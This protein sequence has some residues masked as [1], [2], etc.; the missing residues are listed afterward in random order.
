[1]KRNTPFQKKNLRWLLSS[2]LFLLLFLCLFLPVSELFRKKYTKADMVHSFYSL[3]K[4]SLDV[5]ALGS[6]HAYDSFS[7]NVLWKEQGFTSYMLGSP[8]Q[9]LPMSY[10]L[11][12]EAL[13]YQKPQVVLLETYGFSFENYYEDEGKLRTAFDGIPLNNVKIE[14]VE[15]FFKGASLAEKMTYYVPFCIYHSRWDSLVSRDF[16]AYEGNFL[17]GAYLTVKKETFEMPSTQ[18]VPPLPLPEKA[19]E[20][21]EKIQALC[22]KNHIQL[23]VYSAPIADDQEGEFLRAIGVNKTLAGYLQEKQIP[24]LDFQGNHLVVF[25]YADDFLSAGHLRLNGQEKLTAYLGSYL[26]QHYPLSG[27]KGDSFYVSWDKDYSVYEKTVEKRRG[28]E[29]DEQD[30]MEDDAL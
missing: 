25:D 23:L 8:K 4:D 13:K 1:M 3:K 14:M 7:P 2:A 24:Y 15:T 28:N 11:L 20:Y 21:F 29:D 5:L 30:I 16:K 17:K 18:D 26:R 9:T 22:E 6:S 10:L 19:M 27:H 12:K